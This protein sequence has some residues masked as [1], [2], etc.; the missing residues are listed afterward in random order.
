M[1]LVAE[2]AGGLV[3]LYYGGE[4]LVRGAVS[5]ADRSGASPLIIGLSVVAAGT[6]A[7]EFFVSLIS[8][9]EDKPAIAIGNVVGSNIANL[10]LVLGAA[11]LIW[12][13][14]VRRTIILWDGRVLIAA[15]IVFC[16]LA[17]LGEFDRIVGVVMA[18]GLVAYLYWS[19]RLDRKNTRA[20]LEIEEEVAELGRDRAPWLIAVLLTAGFAG[21][22]AGSELLVD[23]AVGIAANAGLSET[24]IGVTLVAIGTSLPELAAAIAAARNRQT[25]LALGNVIGSCIFNILAI[26]G[27]V[28][29]IEPLAVP[30]EILSFDLWA[31]GGVTL[32]FVALALAKPRLGRTIG[33]AMLLCYAAYIVAQFTG[34]SAMPTIYRPA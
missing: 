8:A 14:I 31:M 15:T 11:A 21:V 4:W 19:Y 16:A 32:A 26:I 6:S 7:P 3:L 10:L 24:A 17:S 27:I 1:L 34:L 23:G 28:S 29:A 22:I 2:V 30:E 9:L 20:R 13:V 25:E 12:P 18:G 33:V 5:L